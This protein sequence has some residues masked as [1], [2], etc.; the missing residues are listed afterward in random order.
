MTRRSFFLLFV[1]I[2]AIL[3]VLWL[4]PWKPPTHP[5]FDR[6]KNALPRKT[7]KVLDNGERFVLLAK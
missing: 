2:V 5:E 7:M 4:K 6:N 1:G 3:G